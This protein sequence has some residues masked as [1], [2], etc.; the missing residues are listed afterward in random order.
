[1]TNPAQSNEIK[2]PIE[3]AIE[4]LRFMKDKA[5]DAFSD[6]VWG[7]AISICELHLEEEKKLLTNKIIQK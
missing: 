3:K 2:T 6:I 5:N 1:M 7:M 4:D